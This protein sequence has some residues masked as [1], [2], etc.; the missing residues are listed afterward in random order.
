MWGVVGRE[1]NHGDTEGTEKSGGM[2]ELQHDRQLILC[3]SF[4][5]LFFLRVLRVSM[6]NLPTPATKDNVIVCLAELDTPY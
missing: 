5:R 6:V 4:V 1:N 3:R 2:L